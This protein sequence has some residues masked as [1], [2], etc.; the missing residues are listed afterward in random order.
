[1]S[2]VYL[3]EFK[4][5]DC[6]EALAR[7]TKVEPSELE[8]AGPKELSYVGGRPVIG[9]SAWSNTGKTYFLEQLIPQLIA[10]GIRPALI[11]HHGHSTGCRPGSAGFCSDFESGE[12]DSLRLARAGAHDIIVSSDQGCMQLSYRETEDEQ[13]ASQSEQQTRELCELI[14]RLPKD[15][16]LVLVEGYKKATISKLIVNRSACQKEAALP[17]AELLE[18]ASLA[19]ISDCAAEKED[20]RGYGIRYFEIDNYAEIADYLVALLE[21][22]ELQQAT[23][24]KS[25][26]RGGKR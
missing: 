23:G 1:M 26:G 22:A 24:H 15:C 21:S 25:S 12:K 17:S 3:P 2:M 6:R 10:R 18:Q 19:W 20:A 8:K 5:I 13:A 9:L 11:K 4:S 14:G 16:P 7:L